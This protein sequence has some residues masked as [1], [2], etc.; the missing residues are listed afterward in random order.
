MY[1][2]DVEKRINK[3]TDALDKLN[4][5]RQKEN[6]LLKEKE[7]LL[8]KQ[9]NVQKAQQKLEEAKRTGDY[10]LIKKRNEELEKAQKENNDLLY[11]QNFNS[12]TDR[13]ND[14]KNYMEDY[15]SKLKDALSDDKL[16]ELAKR[17][18]GDLTPTINS[19]GKLSDKIPET[20][21]SLNKYTSNLTNEFDDFSKILDNIQK[22][23]DSINVMRL[24]MVDVGLNIPSTNNSDNSIT[25]SKIELNN[26]INGGD[27]KEVN[28][29]LEALEY[30][31]GE[32][33][34]NE[35]GK[36]LK[37]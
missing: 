16:D 22:K 27:T 32:R 34:A 10:E 36:L 35:I 29:K 9:N 37:N 12:N 18:I 28:K 14:E 5:K 6:D 33:I 11:E 21:D 30:G 13:I 20:F 7:D 24:P 2:D 3:E 25:I 31:L 1:I 19:L 8:D 4:E 17:G 23:I 15:L 26:I